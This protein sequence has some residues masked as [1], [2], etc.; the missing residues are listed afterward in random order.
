M[1]SLL[2]IHPYKVQGVWVF[3]DPRVG[4]V[5]EPFVSG[6]DVAIDRMVETIPDAESGVTMFFSANRFPG[7]QHEFQWRREDTGGNWYY[8]TEYDLEGWLCP[9][10]FKYFETAPR[11]LFVQVK[12]RAG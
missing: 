9:A 4:L 6:A 12:P 5:Q 10:L 1:N 8:S 2:V 11:Q 7:C 3:D